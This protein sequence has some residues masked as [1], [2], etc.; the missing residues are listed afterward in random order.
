M[1]LTSTSDNV[2]TGLRD[3]GL[4]ARIG[5]GE[6]LETLDKLGEISS[7]LD[8]DGDL[9]DGGHG[10]P[11]DLHVVRGLRGSEGTALEQELVN[12]DETND[13]TTWAVLDGLDVTTH[14]E[15]GTL[16]RLDEEIVLLARD[17]VGALDTDLGACTD[18]TGEDTTESV[19]ASLIRCGHH[20]GDVD[21]EGAV[22]VAVADS[23]G[24][25]VVHGT[26]VKGLDT[27]ALRSG[28]RG[29]VDDYHLQEGV[30]S[31][32]EL[33]HDDLEEGLALEIT[34]ILSELDVKLLEHGGSGI[35]L[36]V[37]DGV[38]D[39]EDRVEDEHVEGTL[40]LLAISVGRLGCPLLGVRV[41][42]VVA[43][44]LS[45]HLLLVDT[46][47]LGVTGSELTEGE[48]PSVKTG[49]EGNGT[50]FRVDLDVAESFVVVGGNNDV[51]T[52]DGTAK[53]LVEGLLVDLELEKST[54]NLVDNDDGLDTLGQ[55]L[56]KDSLGLD[57][58][59]LNAIDDDESTI[60]DTECGR[61]LRGEVDVT[62]GI[63]QVNQEPVA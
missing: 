21:T 6:T 25:L 14:H 9:H 29:E 27:V 60:G 32:Q 2:L 15:D 44:Q 38:E 41:E 11:H 19:E 18:G 4:D 3:P 28:G 40:E 56:T 54:V 47:F 34:L 8:L 39:A 53:R 59:T 23:D 48:G 58:D 42:V 55:G 37:H 49:T 31:G 16:H 57:A 24:G 63:D 7:V 12:T 5:L 1:K 10:E 13:V 46:E 61:D 51:D 33:A 52:L 35:L 26:L 22:R 17:V 50:P 45:H 30:T 20:L 36:V 43:P 62:R